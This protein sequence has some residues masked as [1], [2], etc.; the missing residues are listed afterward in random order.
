MA[1]VLINGQRQGW[2]DIEF[3][4]GTRR[5]TGITKM[6][7]TSEQDKSNEMGQG[8]EPVH[9]SRSNKKYSGE[10]E[11]F[12]YEVMAMLEALPEGKDLTDVAPFTVSIVFM[13]TG[14]DKLKRIDVP[15]TEFLTGG[16]NIDVKQGDKS[17]PIKLPLIIGKPIYKK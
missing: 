15:M 7:I 16:L 6:S 17:I 11:L 2:G 14:G 9:R 5:V 8:N 12:H 3:L 4:I 13:P 1:E 10:L